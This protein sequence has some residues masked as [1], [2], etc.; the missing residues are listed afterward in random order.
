MGESGEGSEEGKKR[1]RVMERRGEE[2]EGDDRKKMDENK[3]N[4]KIDELG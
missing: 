3:K 1:G 4:K 2:E